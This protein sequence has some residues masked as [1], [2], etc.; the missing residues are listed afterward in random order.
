MNFLITL[1]VFIVVLFLYV[2]I[3]DQFKT[4]DDLDVYEMDYSSNT[5]LQEMCEIRQPLLFNF[6]VVEPKFFYDMSPRFILKYGGS[7]DVT[8]KDAHDYYKDSGS[9]ID[10]VSLSLNSTHQLFENDNASHFFSEDNSEFLEESGIVKPIQ[11]L[12]EWFKPVFNV[13]KSY[14]LLF[15]SAGSITPLRYHTYYR[16]F[17]CVT[18]G[19][20]RVKMAPWKCAKYLHPINDYEHYEFRSPVHPL[21]PQPQYAKDFDKT[22]FLEFDVQEGYAF[23]VPPY[24]WYSIQY[25]DANTFITCASYVT[26]MNCISNIPNLGIH[27]LQQQNITKKITKI[28]TK[29]DDHGESAPIISKTEDNPEHIVPETSSVIPCLDQAVDASDKEK[30]IIEDPL[31]ASSSSSSPSDIISLS[32]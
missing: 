26:V 6:N 11:D 3:M 22:K 27:W 15:G 1:F 7:Y 32:I 12:D 18:S 17:L 31:V 23:Y 28:P 8:I 5:N 21:L 24:W 4:G 29:K 2:Y 13:H 9:C 10:S 14:D 25:S 20:I 19:S 16:Q 30:P